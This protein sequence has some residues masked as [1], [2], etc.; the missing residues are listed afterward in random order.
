MNRSRLTDGIA[1]KSI[2]VVGG[3]GTIGAS[4]IRAVLAYKPARLYVVDINENGLTELTR[5]LRSAHDIQVPEVY[6]AYPFD[7]M[8]PVFGKMFEVEGPFEVVANFAAHKH[9]RSEKDHYSI[10]AMLRNNVLGSIQLLEWLSRYPPEHFFCVSTDKAANPVNIMGASKKLMEEVIMSYA[11]RLPVTTARFANVAFSN[12]SLLDGFLQRMM[13]RQPLTA[14]SNVRR[15]FV[16]PGE[17]GQICL[18]ACILGKSGDIFFP[19]LD[20][21]SMKTFS[22]I[23]LDFL[24]AWGYRA[25]RCESEEEAKRK[26]SHLTP[27]M[28]HYPVYFFP[29]ETSGE[30]LYEEFYSKDEAVDFDQFKQLG[31]ITH[32]QHDAAT[33]AVDIQKGL[34][35][36]FRRRDIDKRMIVEFLEGHLPTFTHMETGLS[37]DQK[38]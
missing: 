29:S 6:K 38:M 30:K 20:P 25:A 33:S 7:F 10:E 28:G 5:D 17:S 22:S 19:K 26:A 36:L 4:F 24:Q 2:L 34:T 35:E 31:V 18:L 9:V 27:D 32:S 8:G 12:G 3:A 16:S 11:D 21:K 1:G 15:Y 13:K 23:A 14:P 37:L